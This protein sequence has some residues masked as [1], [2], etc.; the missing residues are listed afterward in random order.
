MVVGNHRPLLEKRIERGDW[1]LPPSARIGRDGPTQRGPKVGA[2]LDD[3]GVARDGVLLALIRRIPERKR[4]IRGDRKPTCEE[5]VQRFTGGCPRRQ[6]HS[7]PF[8]TALGG[9]GRS[10]PQNLGRCGV[11]LGVN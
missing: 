4:D 6:Q 5:C 11:N 3:F 1:R 2:A 8:T 10:W 7:Q 9:H